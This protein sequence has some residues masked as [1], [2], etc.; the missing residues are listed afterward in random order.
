M[1]HVCN[2]CGK[3]FRA[4]P[5]EKPPDHRLLVGDS[6]RK[7][8]VSKAMGSRKAALFATDPP[9][10]VDYTGA[11]RPN[12]SGKDWSGSYREIDIRDAE[13]FFLGVFT[14]AAA[15]C[16]DNAAWYCW[17]AHKR[18][19]LIESI[20]ESLGVINHQQI[21]WVKPLAVHT[22][23]FW[24]WRHEACLMGWKQGNKPDHDGDN[25]HTLT[26]VWECDWEGTCRPV[27]NAH[28]TE[29]PAEL[30]RRPMRKHTK[31]G[32]V[33]FEPCLGSGTQMVA[34][35]QTGRLCVGIEISPAFA[36]VALE[37]LSALGLS[38]RYADA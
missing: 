23:S 20:W 37:R 10:L 32:E 24:P 16:R 25:S 35:E 26:T 8:D 12:D 33:C 19:A 9:F 2:H 31:P 22:Y 5:Q 11:D 7:E 15:V 13:T 29:K 4:R 21:V 3:E 28:P 34:A 38:P 27:G 17:H 18:A 30:F 6:T 14:N 1:K 36:A